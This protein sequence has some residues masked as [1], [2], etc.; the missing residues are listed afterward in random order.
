MNGNFI[1]YIRMCVAANGKLKKFFKAKPGDRYIIPADYENG[2]YNLRYITGR[3]TPSSAY[4]IPYQEDFIDFYTD[5]EV[6]CEID[7]IEE[8]IRWV[9]TTIRTPTFRFGSLEMIYLAFLMYKVFLMEWNGKSWEAVM[10]ESYSV[11]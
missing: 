4:Y 10:Y 7:V 5:R 2:I 9:K 3:V 1:K 8:I 6:E 11:R